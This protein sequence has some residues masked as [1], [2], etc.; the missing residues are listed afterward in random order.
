MDLGLDAR[1]VWPEWPP[2]RMVLERGLSCSERVGFW[3]SVFSESDEG[4]FGL[5][6]GLD[7]ELQLKVNAL[8]DNLADAEKEDE[9]FMAGKGR[10]MLKWTSTPPVQSVAETILPNF[11]NS[12]LF[13]VFIFSVLDTSATLSP[14]HPPRLAHLPGDVKRRYRSIWAK[15]VAPDPSKC[16]PSG[17]FCSNWAEAHVGLIV[18]LFIQVRSSPNFGLT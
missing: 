4:G 17:R 8:E 13:Q 11:R 6:G 14:S 18:F 3:P 5:G 2:V 7:E 10:G 16:T 15:D 1:A 12:G 9:C